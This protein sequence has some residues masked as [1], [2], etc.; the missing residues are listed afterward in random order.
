VNLDRIAAINWLAP[1][2]YGRIKSKK[3]KSKKERKIFW[4]KDTPLWGYSVRLICTLTGAPP[5][6]MASPCT[7]R[8]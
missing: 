5:V 1:R 3:E 6:L 4:I 2:L 8:Q 7:E